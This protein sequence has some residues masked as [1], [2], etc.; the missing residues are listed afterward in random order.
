LIPNNLQLLM[1]KLVDEF[2]SQ[3]VEDTNCIEIPNMLVLEEWVVELNQKMGLVP[4]PRG[5]SQ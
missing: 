4:C 1:D 5:P 2:S 3:V